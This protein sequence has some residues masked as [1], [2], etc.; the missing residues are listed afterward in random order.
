MID[1]LGRAGNLSK[2][3][4]MINKSPLSESPLLWRTFVNVCK[5]CSDLQCGMWA[6]R[7]LLDL[8]PNE[9]SSYILVSNM[10]AEGGMLEEAAKIRTAMNDLK[11]F[12]ETGSSWIEIDNEVHY[13]IASDKNHP[14]SREIYANL[15]LL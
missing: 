2:A 5:L 7:K 15:D 1:L 10:Y 8:A 4:N 12:K 11:L 9:A 3:M 14:Q 6:S 13:F